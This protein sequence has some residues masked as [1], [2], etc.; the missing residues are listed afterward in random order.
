MREYHIIV[1]VD[2]NEIGV[3]LWQYL[4]VSI[5][6]AMIMPLLGSYHD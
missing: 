6:L 1:E 3:A 2:N 4:G 5:L